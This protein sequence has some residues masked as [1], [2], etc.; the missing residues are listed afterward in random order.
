MKKIVSVLLALCLLL[1]VPLQHLSAEEDAPQ[2]LEPAPQEE[3]QQ[4]E[5]PKAPENVPPPETLPPDTAEEPTPGPS[6]DG[7]EAEGGDTTPPTSSPS[8]APSDSP[9]PDPSEE[10]TPSPAPGDG[11]E[12][13]PSPSPET[14]VDPTGDLGEAEIE[15][16]PEAGID[17]ALS[18]FD[19]PLFTEGYVRLLGPGSVELFDRRSPQAEPVAWAE[20]GAVAYL[21]QRTT[22]TPQEGDREEIQI[23][24]A[25]GILSFWIDATLI[26][27]MDG[28]E[29]DA[30]RE[31]LDE[32]VHPLGN[33]L[34]LGMVEIEWAEPAAEEPPAMMLMM[35]MLPQVDYSLSVRD[36]PMF[37]AGYVRVFS[38]AEAALFGG[39]DALLEAVAWAEEGTVAYLSQ[40][41]SDAPQEGEREEIQIALLEGI[42]SFWIDASL[43]RPM[44]EEE[45][46]AYQAGLSDAF[47]PLTGSGLPL[48]ICALRL[49]ETETLTLDLP[50]RVEPL[51]EGGFP[52]LAGDAALLETVST[53]G[54]TLRDAFLSVLSIQG[55]SVDLSAFSL[56]LE[57]CQAAYQA[58]MDENSALFHV[59]G[60]AAADTLG[61]LVQALR[62]VYRMDPAQYDQ[63]LEDMDRALDT[64]L[65]QMPEHAQSEA[66]RVVALHDLFLLSYGSGSASDAHALLSGGAG[67]SHAFAQAFAAAL[68]RL[69]IDAVPVRSGPMGRVWNFVRVGGHWYHA[70][71]FSDLEDSAGFSLSYDHLLCSDEK[72][73][74]STRGHHGWEPLYTAG[75]TTYDDMDLWALL[76]IEDELDLFHTGGLPKPPTP[77]RATFFRSVTLE[78]VLYEGLMAEA[79]LIDVSAFRLSPADFKVR[80]QDFVNTYPEFFFLDNGYSYY[81]AGGVVT[82]LVPKYLPGYTGEE[83]IR[84]LATFEAYA[85][86]II[87][88]IPAGT[89]DLEKAL[90]V[91]DFFA[92]N[93]SYS[94]SGSEN[95]NPYVLFTQKHGVCQA[96]ALGYKYVMDQLGISAMLVTSPYDPITDT[97]MGHGWNLVRLGGSWYHLDATW[98]DP[99]PDIEGYVDHRYFLTSDQKIR[100]LGHYEYAP[101][102]MAGSKSYDS[103]FWQDVDVPFSY[104]EKGW[105]FMQNG[106]IRKWIPAT[107]ERQ[108]IHSLGVAGLFTSVVAYNGEL[109]FSDFSGIYSIPLSGGDPQLRY[110]PPLESGWR[111]VGVFEKETGLYYKD[112]RTGL[113][114]VAVAHRLTN[115]MLGYKYT[116]Q[117]QKIVNFIT[118]IY[119][120]VLQRNPMTSEADAWLNDMLHQGVT[121]A[122]ACEGFIL[123]EEFTEKD[124]PHRDFIAALYETCLG[125][126]C[127]AQELDTWA[128]YLDFGCSRRFV[129][130]EFMKSPEFNAL[131]ANYGIEAGSIKMTDLVDTHFTVAMFVGRMYQVF[132]GRGAQ[133]HEVEAWLNDMLRRGVAG[134]SVAEGFAYSDEFWDR[135]LTEEQM[136]ASMYE[137]MLGRPP[138]DYELAA[139]MNSLPEIGGVKNLFFE[140]VEAPE[141][142]DL[143]AE[144]GVTP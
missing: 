105:Y 48:G 27:P 111:V 62:P 141:Y 83:R 56:T 125:R 76:L 135:G 124:I 17:Y 100:A 110:E 92:V 1:S 34:P 53:A 115:D 102:G 55:E 61:D 72:I 57:Q 77:A 41:A 63:A 95:H 70:D 2:A 132:L 103:A 97:G 101:A 79:G 9:S 25:E 131:C 29:V 118:R 82:R 113:Y 133:P 130:N 143:M 108:V 86:S 94:P 69:H 140:F 19:N 85:R 90:Y 117:E 137:A 60:D 37:T 42:Q 45:V 26:R 66:Q 3:L 139:W 93:F 21:S 121:G 40:R 91:Y 75:D 106:E 35:D 78:M 128:E 112:T 64:L 23:A 8:A 20:E 71:L 4:P 51:W 13:T 104:A 32:R 84:K 142:H 44:D 68:S 134:R 5:E 138:A 15:E 30:Y 10:E 16:T 7:D 123:S 109:L 39:A 52:E 24:L 122:T 144:Y 99:I 73:S 119:Q 12:D 127:S 59:S 50:L 80:F 98:A 129:L 136:V 87:S 89:S 126:P 96:Y 120:M 38:Q 58:L 67:S 54:Q 22:T 46:A 114:P 47:W 88:G 36:N 14:S 31:E 65:S 11:A 33:G 81:H 43:V 107:D 6:T 74:K 28:E 18:V 116:A 49:A